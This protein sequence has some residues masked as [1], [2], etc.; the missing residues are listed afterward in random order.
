VKT[1]K[2]IAQ[3]RISEESHNLLLRTNSKL[4]REQKHCCSSIW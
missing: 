4:G 1:V 3:E 2:F